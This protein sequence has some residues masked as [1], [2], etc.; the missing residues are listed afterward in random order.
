[1]I[2]LDMPTGKAVE[3]LRAREKATHTR[4]DIHEVDTEYLAKCRRTALA[5]AGLLGWR[6]VSC[7]DGTGAVRSVEDI[8]REIWDIITAQNLL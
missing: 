1:M 3:M 7:V 2:Y 6:R 5:A 8:H 4:G